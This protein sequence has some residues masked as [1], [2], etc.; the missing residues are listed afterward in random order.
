MHLHRQVQLQVNAL[1]ELCT[2]LCYPI[3]ASLFQAPAPQSGENNKVQVKIVY[4][5]AL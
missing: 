1:D 5:I 2:A 4:Q 3:Y